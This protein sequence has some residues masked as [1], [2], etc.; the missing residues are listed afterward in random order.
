MREL[1]SR[2]DSLH[3]ESSLLNQGCTRIP[4]T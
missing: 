2:A 3:A 1:K 4:K